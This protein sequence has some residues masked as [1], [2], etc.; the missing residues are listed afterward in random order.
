MKL[1]VGEAFKTTLRPGLFSY[2][3]FL[4]VS[5]VNFKEYFGEKYEDK[6]CQMCKLQLDTQA[7]SVHR[8]KIKEDIKMN[9]TYSDI[10]QENVPS[11]ISQTLLRSSKLRKEALISTVC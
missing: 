7:H 3:D 5:A 8:E 6:S 11:N 2:L 4:Q 10:F 1:P 9:G